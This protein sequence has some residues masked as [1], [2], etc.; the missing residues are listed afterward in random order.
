[1][2]RMAGRTFLW[3]GF[4]VSAVIPAA[5]QDPFQP[6]PGEI[7][8][9][10]SCLGCHDVRNIQVQAL[11]AADWRALIDTMIENG[12][13][14]GEDDIPVLIDYLVGRHGPLPEGEGREVL[15]YSCTICHDLGRVREHRVSPEH[16]QETLFAMLNEGAYLTDEEFYTLLNYLSLHFSDE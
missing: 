13:T 7:V 16:W 12:A 10:R 2:K 15:R 11:D 14:V 6:D 4:S 3:L 8:M 1:M 5:A 9:N